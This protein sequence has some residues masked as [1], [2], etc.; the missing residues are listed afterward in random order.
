MNMRMVETDR[1]LVFR[2]HLDESKMTRD[3]S[4]PPPPG[5]AADDRPLVPDPNWCLTLTWGKAPPRGQTNA[6]YRAAILDEVRLHAN[7]RLAALTA[8]PE[9]TGTWEPL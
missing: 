5:G 3:P 7:E 8:S 6:Q 1:S 4:L 9:F 2:V